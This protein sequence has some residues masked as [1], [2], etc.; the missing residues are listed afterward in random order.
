[1]KVL[2][3]EDDRRMAEL[4]RRGLSPREFALLQTFLRRPDQLLSRTELL[5]RVWDSAYEADSNV[6]DVYVRYLRRKADPVSRR[7][8]A[9]DRSGSWLPARQRR[10]VVKRPI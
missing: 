7:R 6:V 10:H 8:A 1:M 3:V 4:L 2:V 5:D 9:G